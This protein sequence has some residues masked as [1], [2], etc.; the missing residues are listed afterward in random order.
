[1]DVSTT[2]ERRILILTSHGIRTN[3]KWQKRLEEIVLAEISARNA[4][5]AAAATSTQALK[6]TFRHNDY[7]Y[8][9]IFS[10]LNPFRRRAETKKFTAR[11]R[12]YI[13]LDE[14]DEINL[15]GHSFGTHIICHSLLAI[16]ESLN[17]KVG[18]VIL[19]A[20]VLP[21][22][23]PW[24]ALF[25]T[26][27]HRLVNECGDN[28]LVLVFN[29]ILP[30]GS[31]L[32]GRRG[33]VGITGDHFRNRFFRFGHS[34]YFKKRVPDGTDDVWFMHK[35]WAP[36]L[37]GERTTP[38]VDERE[39][40]YG[41][42]FVG[43][44][45]DQ[46]ENLKWLIPLGLASVLALA[47]LYLALV[48]RTNF[49]LETLEI[50]GQITDAVERRQLYGVAET[51]KSRQDA[52]EHMAD[53]PTTILENLVRRGARASLNPAQWERARVAAKVAI[54]PK[55][56]LA[57]GEV[58]DVRSRGSNF[59]QL[60]FAAK[61][62]DDASSEMEPVRARQSVT[63]FDLRTGNPSQ[64]A[65]WQW[66]GPYASLDDPIPK[67]EYGTARLQPA[68]VHGLQGK[69][70][71]Q[72][73]TSL[74]GDGL[75]LWDIT[76]ATPRSSW[77]PESWGAVP[78]VEA[79]P[80]GDAGNAIALTRE[81]KAIVLRAD[82]TAAELASPAALVQVVSNRSCDRFA[83]ATSRQAL[84]AWTA[85]DRYFSLLT[86][87]LVNSIEF[88]ATQDL[89]LVNSTLKVDGEGV[90]A[91]LIDLS[92]TRIG[93]VERFGAL[94]A[95]MAALSPSGRQIAV[96]DG[97]LCSIHSVGSLVKEAEDA[98]VPFSLSCPKD[99]TDA[100]SL[101]QHLRFLA[102]DELVLTTRADRGSFGDSQVEVLDLL[103]RRSS[104][105]VR[106]SRYDII[107]LDASADGS[108]I[109]TTAGD[110]ADEGY[111]ADRGF[112]VWSINSQAP[113]FEDARD[114]ASNW[115]ARRAWL[116]PDG[117]RAVVT[118]RRFEAS[119]SDFVFETEAVD[120]D[121]DMQVTDSVN[122][123]V[124]PPVWGIEL[125]D[126]EQPRKPCT[127]VP[128]GVEW[129][130]EG[131][132]E[133]LTNGCVAGGAF[134][135][136]A[137]IDAKPVQLRFSQEADRWRIRI[138]QAGSESIKAV[139]Y[140][141]GTP[142]ND[143]I[144]DF[145]S[146][147][148]T[149]H[150]FLSHEDGTMTRLDLDKDLAATRIRNATGLA[151][152][153]GLDWFDGRQWLRVETSDPESA[154]GRSRSL[155]FYDA[156]GHL[157]R[158]YTQ[159]GKP[160]VTDGA[161]GAFDKNGH[162]WTVVDQPLGY[163]QG[164]AHPDVTAEHET[165]TQRMLINLDTGETLPFGCDGEPY[166]DSSNV[167]DPLPVLKVSRSGRFL[168]AGNLAPTIGAAENNTEMRL[169]D[170]AEKKCLGVFS[171]GGEIYDFGAS[172]DGRLLVTQGLTELN[173]W[174]VPTN[175]VVHTFF[176]PTRI[177]QDRLGLRIILRV[178]TDHP[179]V[180]PI[181]PDLEKWL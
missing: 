30:F 108:V 154:N 181:P 111:G 148:V 141:D 10:F 130:Q 126:L 20:S 178:E 106:G 105:L 80:C 75:T 6:V 62:S 157:M 89:L 69:L 146:D 41:R 66:S 57:T 65:M 101:A 31:G 128:D 120:L 179:A 47:F 83:A 137:R 163:Q 161:S 46:S 61:N 18:T 79:K 90:R 60:T 94:D 176:G 40:R 102:S 22:A 64:S 84:V 59:V 97:D 103:N 113:V 175:T 70:E 5:A 169:F 118:W 42:V 149:R 16:G 27:I 114:P 58:T 166:L 162:Y 134:L 29:A 56:L 73:A 132:E 12:D 32:A 26:G 119:I 24:D 167:H 116:T 28:D 17:Q 174:H 165:L 99:V 19:A 51:I 23:F 49:N 121:P 129:P 8:F 164:E 140:R 124:A 1:M 155:K 35:Y 71:D 39:D 135:V 133:A 107:S 3:A 158:E 172:D 110:S 48:G 93:Q 131:S 100:A 76:S 81:G 104:W 142:V 4:A 151:N 122:A 44:L 43:W 150:V 170:L 156:D 36:L 37:L 33:F 7:R 136:R 117:T 96:K 2:S 78:L 180:W 91:D 138:R 38:F 68:G 139:T 144:R 52:I 54:R 14:F 168:G 177:I 50:A 145:V 55:R 53:R 115:E 13:A 123:M 85:P 109:T 86:G 63:T 11:L 88:S 67:D 125:S 112:Y 127:A 95:D 9:S 82:N 171:H 92:A 173:L 87:R 143:D 74:T 153:F 21:G 147:P 77:K 159:V 15:V 34:G 98:S 72:F 45:V 152:D 160:G 25:R